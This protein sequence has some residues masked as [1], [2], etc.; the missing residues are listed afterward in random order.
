MRIA[1]LGAGGTMGLPMARNLARA[2][3][4][5]RGWNRSPDKAEPLADDGGEVVETAADAV[6][7]ADVVV[8]M[9]S[10]VEAVAEAVADARLDRAADGAVWI[11]MST[12]GLDGIEQLATL[13]DEHG[14]AFVDAPV[15][16]TKDPAERGA[17][18][19]LG[20][21]PGEV[22]DRLGPIFDAVGQKTLWVGE[23]GAA[24]RLK[25]VINAWIVAVVEGAAETVAL[26][27][28][29][30]VDP[31]LFLEAIEGGPLD[32][33]YLRMKA[34]MMI[35]RDFQPSFRLALAAKDARLAVEAA[36][37]HGA[38]LPALAA[39]RRR[40]EEGAERHGDEDMA[41]TYLTSAGAKAGQP[42]S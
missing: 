21:G 6:A 26:A 40:L 15:L 30:G 12:V 33:P 41:A 35:D 39:I 13:A 2:G 20:S 16:G 29:V 38:S 3:F 36:E 31:N 28:A 5:V 18:V 37:R 8:T 32:L 34:G 25:V 1:F 9:L 4:E 24:S 42:G 22:R 10:D 7:G 19:I 27:E 23:A 14:I 17:L 11:Q